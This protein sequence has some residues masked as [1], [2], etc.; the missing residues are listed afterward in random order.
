MM[1][2]EGES[3]RGLSVPTYTSPACLWSADSGGVL[4]GFF[5]HRF[6][7]VIFVARNS[8]PDKALTSN[9]ADSSEQDG[10]CG[11]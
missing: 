10:E 3:N 6:I 8:G 1:D 5:N 2:G 4:S 9:P 11:E 7:A